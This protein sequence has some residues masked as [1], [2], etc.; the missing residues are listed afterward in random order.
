M[1]RALS[2]RGD[3]SDWFQQTVTGTDFLDPYSVAAA[4]EGANV[5]VNAVSL[6]V[7]HG[8][9]TFHR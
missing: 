3:C 5:V 7:E 9:Q 1:H 8:E 2:Y 4:V 6:Y